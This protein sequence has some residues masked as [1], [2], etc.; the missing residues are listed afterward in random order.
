M[1]S[2]RRKTLGRIGATVVSIC[3]VLAA[4]AAAAP[5]AKPAAETAAA[6]ALPNPGT[7]TI[8]PDHSFAYFGALHHIVGLVRGRFDH[9]AGT[10]TV[11][12][13]P[14][15]CAVDVAIDPASVST[16]V[17]ER[18]EDLRGPAYFDVKSFPGITY[19][20]R[21]I[22]RLPGGSWA[23]DGLLTLHGVT[24]V[25]PLTFTFNGAFADIKPG[26]PARVAFHGSA[27][28][29]RADFGMG[30]RDK[31]EVGAPSE[32]DVQIEIDVEADA[33]PSRQ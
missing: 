18:D 28:T 13:D 16:Q 11:A 8:D 23:M 12:Q 31:G 9:V 29:K 26:K 5:P 27:S 25:V 33:K 21:G 24:K 17:S 7:Y 30:A 2:R 1:I 14:A 32:P 22:R 3:A 4:I 6:Q 19:R 15:A 10:I 20:G